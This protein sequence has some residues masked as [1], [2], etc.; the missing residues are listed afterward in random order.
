[1]SS[2][3]EGTLKRPMKLYTRIVLFFTIAFSCI[4]IISNLFVF[5]FSQQIV[6]NESQANL[7]K[8]NNFIINVINENKT[9]LMKESEE[10]RLAYIAEKIYPNVKDNT[11]VSY[12]LTD[13]NAYNYSSTDTVDA[14]LNEDNFSKYNIDLFKLKITEKATEVKYLSEDIDVDTFNYSG[15]D[16]YYIGSSYSVDDHYTVYI[17]TVK[18]LDDS[19]M[20]MTILYLIQISIS[21]ISLGIV[22]LMGIYG[23]KRALKPLIDIANTTR[24][25]TENNLSIRIQ[26][27]GNKDELDQMIIALNQMIGQL[28]SAFDVQKQFVSDASH[29]LRVPL[30]VLQGYADILDGWGSD[31]EAIREE[32]ITS[33]NAEIKNM[34]T[35]V[36]ELLLLTRLENRYYSERFERI[37]FT[38][39]LTRVYDEWK[40]IDTKHIF[41]LVTPNNPCYVQC[42][43]GLILQA[44]RGII[45]NAVKYTPEKGTITIILE[46]EAA[47]LR[48]HINDTGIGIPKED[49]SKI[50]ER[51]Y[52]V[53]S[54]RSRKS[55]G[56]G[57][58]LAIIHSIVHLHQGTLTINSL[59]GQGTQVC[60]TLPHHLLETSNDPH[61]KQLTHSLD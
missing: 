25:I 45:D 17:Q 39:L 11:L 42:N 1:M 28:E 4:L 22:V 26:E 53:N 21:I 43:E 3:R 6:F 52:R 12:R 48:L 24:A 40:M 55:G 61:K 32:A 9:E 18:N 47:F 30:T 19:L 20:F 15:S 5:Y 59:M 10:N 54:D 37:N 14:V 36:D 57:L 33:I 49:L 31:N 51:F 50:C 8:F 41:T 58:G 13:T 46:V 60:I 44:V 23:T 29:E 2:N 56:V 35:I 38:Q 16:Y 7:I 34:Q 27:T